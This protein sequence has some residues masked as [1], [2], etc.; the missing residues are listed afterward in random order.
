M[1][2]RGVWNLGDGLICRGGLRPATKRL[3]VSPSKQFSDE[4]GALGIYDARGGGKN[5]QRLIEKQW[6]KGRVSKAPFSRDGGC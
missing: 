2:L 5:R 6:G 1:E 3:A 4:A